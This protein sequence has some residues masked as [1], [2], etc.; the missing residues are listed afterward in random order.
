MKV[1][2]FNFIKIAGESDPT[3]VKRKALN[4]N[5]EF[6]NITQEESPMFKEQDLIKVHFQYTL[7]YEEDKKEAKPKH[8]AISLEGAIILSAETAES[9]EI[10]KAW[11]K[12]SL[13]DAFKVPLFNV[14]LK[15]CTP[16]AIQLEDELNLPLHVP[17]PQVK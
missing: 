16:K 2:G 6:M 14:I 4:T 11:K 8:P 15:K 17:L 10:L 12:K 1:I 7:D 5:I 13:S 3:A 9:K